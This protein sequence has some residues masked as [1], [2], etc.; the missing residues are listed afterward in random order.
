MFHKNNQEKIYIYIYIII[1][2]I[3]IYTGDKECMR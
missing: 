2:I 3:K 1:I